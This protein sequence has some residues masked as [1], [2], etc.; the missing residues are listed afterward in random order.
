MQKMAHFAQNLCK[1]NF[2]FFFNKK[3]NFGPVS[4]VLASNHVI[5]RALDHA[6]PIRMI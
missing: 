2:L 6:K 3:I 1:Q 4:R 5:L